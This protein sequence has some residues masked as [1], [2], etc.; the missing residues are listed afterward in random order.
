MK[1]YDVAIV[2]GGP[3]GLSTALF[4]AYASPALSDRIV[5]LE[6]KTFPRDKICGGAIGARA[7]AL[8]A[9]IDVRVDVPSAVIDGLSIQTQE[10][11][12]CPSPGRIGRVVRRLEYDHELARITRAR[13]IQIEEGASV[14]KLSIDP[15]GV[16]LETAVGTLRAKVVVGA[17]GVGSFVRRTLGFKTGS[18]VAQV[19]ELDTEPVDG[20][21]SR[22]LLHFDFSDRGLTGYAWDF[23]TV[24]N[25]QPLVCR[26]V[27][28]LKLNKDAVDIRAVLEQ[29]LNARGLDMSRYR[30]KRF[31]ERGF[32]RDQPLA[33]PRALLVG[34]AA[35]IDALT[36][37]GIPQ[38]LE[39]GALAGRYLAE[40]IAS[41]DFSFHDWTARVARSTTGMD[42]RVRGWIVPR[43][44]GRRRA[45]IERNVG[46]M[47][48]YMACSLDQF[49][50]R[51]VP[52]LRWWSATGLAAWRFAGG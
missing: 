34:E 12:L 18:L 39:Y 47:P 43:L 5:V 20:D 37:E 8:L 9:S 7:D 46:K 42:L 10:G 28:H 11:L 23:P 27:Y 35:G 19:A 31:A 6:K 26:G 50:G 30:L 41:D 21:P 14:T 2:G 52:P 4:L 16:T 45:W 17:D 51:K 1:S 40:R 49:A 38:A 15:E 33:V 36:G 22:G 13:G 24:V 25:G 44:Y 32:E 3:A 29:R 48:E